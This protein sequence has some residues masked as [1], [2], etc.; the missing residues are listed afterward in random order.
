[1][2]VV[3]HTSTDTLTIKP[4][5]VAYTHQERDNITSTTSSNN[6]TNT[7]NNDAN[8]DDANADENSLGAGG[9]ETQ[10]AGVLL[11]FPYPENGHYRGD[12]D[13]DQDDDDATGSVNTAGGEDEF[14]STQAL[15][16]ETNGNSEQ[17][18]TR[19]V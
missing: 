2:Q 19:S 15:L 4:D 3:S 9:D 18:N 14:L 5:G 13:H 7:G 8:A 1:M 10:P 17:V 12:N 11:N 6:N 16:S